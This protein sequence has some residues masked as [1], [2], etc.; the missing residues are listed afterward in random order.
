MTSSAE[1]VGVMGME[2]NNVVFRF[3][4]EATLLASVSTRHFSSR[5]GAGRTG[6]TKVKGHCTIKTGGGRRVSNEER[7]QHR[8]RKRPSIVFYFFLFFLK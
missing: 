3:E 2:G 1:I 7:R 6:D 4:G 8:P 5:R